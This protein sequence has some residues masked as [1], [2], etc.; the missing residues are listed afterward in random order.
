MPRTSGRWRR[1]ES[2]TDR[3]QFVWGSV[4]PT[5]GPFNWTPTDTLVGA[6]GL[7]RHS[8]GPLLLGVAGMGGPPRPRAPRSTGSQHVQ[9]WQDFL[10]AAV[11]RYGPGGS[12]WANVYRQQ[13]GRG[14]QA[15]ADPVLADLERAQPEE[16]LRAETIGRRVCPAARDLPRRDQEARIPQA[17][18][19]LAGMPGF[20]DSERLGLPRPPLLGAR[21]QELTSTPS[22]CTRTRPTS[23]SSACEVEQA[24]RGDEG[25][26]RP[27]H[28]AVGHRARLGLGAS[29]PLRPQQGHQRSEAA[30]R[31]LL[32]ADPAA[33]ARTGTC[34]ACSGSTG[35]IRQTPS[36]VRCSFC[37]SAGLL[38]SDRTPKPAYQAF[39]RFAGAR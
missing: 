2:A 38:K 15:A 14:R 13:Y 17:R 5:R 35:A 1:P 26:R 3:V 9:A 21:D 12:Y 4:Q 18:V 10:E 19:V 37:A 25:Q 27:G 28:A 20:G 32:Q 8:D 16:V 29:R 30:A 33:S 7:A 24:P 22:P 23:S 31:R 6:S 39:K 36:V 11:A 34:S